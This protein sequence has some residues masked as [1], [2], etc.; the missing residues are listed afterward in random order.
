MAII[1]FLILLLVTQ[2][3]G[4]Y[5]RRWSVADSQVSGES[6]VAASAAVGMG[7]GI[8]VLL[9]LFVLYMG[10]TQWNWAGRPNPGGHLSNPAPISTPVAPGQGVIATASPSASAS[11]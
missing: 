7:A 9:L 11:P 2:A 8:V 10:I 4:Y 6:S 5:R 3:A 1:V